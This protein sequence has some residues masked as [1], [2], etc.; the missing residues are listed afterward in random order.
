MFAM[1][2]VGKTPVKVSE[3]SLGC[4]AIGN[5]YREVSDEDVHALL[6][7]AWSSGIRY[8]DAAPHYGRGLA[9]QRL[10]EFL[11]KV[12]TADVQVSTKVGRVLRPGPELA[13]ADGFV[14]PLPNAVHYDYSGD[15]IRESLDGSFERLQRD[16]ADIIFI[17]D[18]GTDAHPAEAS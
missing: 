8:F 9:E 6:E 1:R 18:I 13:E 2:A 16:F 4:S 3:V 11:A 17:H 7:Y 10:G 5:L 14:N 12:G 15:G